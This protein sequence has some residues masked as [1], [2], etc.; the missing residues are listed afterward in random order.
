MGSLKEALQKAGLKSSKSENERKYR[1]DLKK[2]SEK[3]QY[4]RN[5]CEVCETVQPDVEKFN[6]R[7]PLIAHAKWICV[8]CADRYEIHDDLRLTNQS[9]FAK[10]NR[11]LREYGPT[12]KFPPSVTVIKK[13][14]GPLNVGK[15]RFDKK[16]RRTDK[17][18]NKK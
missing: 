8:A 14:K 1:K 2:K 3:F 16:K 18:F 6:H 12:K 13:D 9:D 17:N 5:F 15:K 11:Y 4:T 7:N 10:Q